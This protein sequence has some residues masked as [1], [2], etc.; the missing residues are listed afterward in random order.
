MP[1]SCSKI[2]ETA[3][4]TIAAYRADSRIISPRHGDCFLFTGGETTMNEQR[5][6]RVYWELILQNARIVSEDNRARLADLA[7]R[8]MLPKDALRQLHAVGILIPS[9]DSRT[10]QN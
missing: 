4:G 1:P 5:T 2:R 9:P 7:R 3:G 10:S 8:N 6:I